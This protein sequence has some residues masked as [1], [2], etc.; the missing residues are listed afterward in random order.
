MGNIMPNYSAVQVAIES[1]RLGY[2]APLSTPTTKD[3][4]PY[5]KLLAIIL[6]GGAKSEVIDQIEGLLTGDRTSIFNERIAY[7]V[8]GIT[9]FEGDHLPRTAVIK[10][11]GLSS[12][13]LELL[14]RSVTLLMQYSLG[15]YDNDKHD[16][17]K[18]GIMEKAFRILLSSELSYDDKKEGLGGLIKSDILYEASVNNRSAQYLSYGTEDK[19]HLRGVLNLILCKQFNAESLSYYPAASLFSKYIE[20]NRKFEKELTDPRANYTFRYGPGDDDL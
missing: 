10:V 5:L 14:M 8:S 20:D 13:N 6:R 18:K 19:V 7:I 3:K 16:K 11:Q 9:H 15:R 4:T 2:W 1:L 12:A 17:H